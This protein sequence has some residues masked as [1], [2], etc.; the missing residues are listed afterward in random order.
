MK[1]RKLTS[2]VNMTS[3]PG[4]RLSELYVTDGLSFASKNRACDSKK[5]EEKTQYNDSPSV[6][7]SL[8]LVFLR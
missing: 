7:F 6:P 5:N 8:V 1:T 4:G 2:S 3:P